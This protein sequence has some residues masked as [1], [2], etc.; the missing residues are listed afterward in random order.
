MAQT[1]ITIT[2]LLDLNDNSTR[3]KIK[4]G[5]VALRNKMKKANAIETSSIKVEICHHDE[6]PPKPC[7]VLYEWKKE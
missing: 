5:V 3:D 4:D 7:E 6:N 1:K 2:A